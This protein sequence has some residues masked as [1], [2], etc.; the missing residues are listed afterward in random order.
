L[1]IVEIYAAP[2]LKNKIVVSQMF[3]GMEFYIVNCRENPTKV[4]LELMIYQ[5]G[6]S[7]V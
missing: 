4:E 5:H 6:G 1:K 2:D 3:A 7:L